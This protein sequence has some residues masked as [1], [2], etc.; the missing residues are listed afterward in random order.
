[1]HSV[2][3]RS[4]FQSTAVLLFGSILLSSCGGGSGTGSGNGGG[5]PPP[6][7][8]FSLTLPGN[9]SVQQGSTTTVSVSVTGI[10][11]FSSPV[12][13][14]LSGVPSGVTATPAQ[15]TLTTGA[16]QQIVIAA[17]A[18]AGAT[19]TDLTVSAT[20][21]ALAHSGQ[22]SLVVSAPQGPPPTLTRTAYVRTD[23]LWDPSFFNFFPQTL[24]VYDQATKRFFVSNTSLNRVDV[25][26][27]TT[28]RQIASIR[29][30]A[31][32]GGDES[33]DHKT[34]YLGTQV[35]DLY[36]IDPVGM[37]VTKRIPSIQIGPAGYAVYEVKALADGKLALLGG[38][39]GIPAVDGYSNFAIWNP[40]NNA[41]EQYASS[42]GAT[43]SATTNSPVCGSLE[44]IAEMTVTADRSKILLT[45]ADSDNTLCMFDPNT[46]TQRLANAP[47]GQPI[48]VPADGK[49]ILIATGNQVTVFDSASLTQTD[50]FEVNP[51]FNN[52]RFILSIDGNTLYGADAGSDGSLIVNWRTHQQSGWMQD[53]QVFDTPGTGLAVPMAI[54][55]TG[56]IASAI[57]HGVAFL[58]GA[59]SLPHA[60]GTTFPFGYN[61][62]IQPSFGPAAG[63]TAVVMT[64]MP[65]TD[66]ENVIFGSAPAQALSPGTSGLK[67]TTPAGTP[68][69]VTVYLNTA[70]L[71]FVLLPD[72]YSYGPSIV[73]VRADAT[74]AEGGGSGTIFGYGFGSAAFQGQAPGFQVAVGGQTAAVTQYL[75]QPYEQTTPYYPFPLEAVQFNFPAGTA[76]TFAD[77]SVSNAAGSDTAPKAVQYLPAVQQFP[78]AGASLIQGVYDS[79]RDV[80]YFTDQTQLRVF[81][82]TKS[83]WL[84]S[85]P[86]PA[87]A[88][89]LF[90]VSLSPNKSTLAVSDSGANLVYILDPDAPATVKTFA[91]PNSGVDQGE[92]PCGLAITDSGIAYVAT[93]Y[94]DFTGGPALH[95]V[96]TSTG[97]VSDYQGLAAGGLSDDAAIRVLLTNDND[98]VF[99]NI[100]GA[101]LSL[102]TA[103]D[104]F[105]FNPTIQGFDYEL[106]LSSNQTWMS[107]S[108]YLMDTNLNI[109]SY[110]TYN[111]RETWNQSA[112]YGEKI[113]ADGNL[114]FAPLMNGLDVIDGRLA[115]LRTRIGLPFTMSSNYDAL[116]D[117]GIDNILV[118][119]TGQT[120]GGVAV[121]DLSS[122]PEPT[123]SVVPQSLLPESSKY[124]TSLT[125]KNPDVRRWMN[126]SRDSSRLPGKL[127][128]TMNS[129]AV[130][131]AHRSPAK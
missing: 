89:R 74:T 118:A 124:S 29:V 78:L 123:S 79:K 76:G 97:V 131:S 12:N 33:V 100:A 52:Y 11:G 87:G 1:M 129:A 122:L 126:V 69:A 34:I 66:I 80:Y 91:L 26:D 106:T 110:V 125:T 32:W 105:F 49:E 96:N 103:T 99:F 23:V 119:I 111:D 42:Y 55:E 62:V 35:G 127:P 115:G 71:A 45:S 75:S 94:V 48:L 61:N 77:V 59:A 8:N 109:E 6:T 54:S 53:F 68:G 7:P 93:F 50:Q 67:L 102:D 121:I 47:N 25:F 57:G 24:V 90:G 46:L 5:T 21:G 81:S 72:G 114:L 3:S 27:A 14:V 10:N 95:K 15:F 101:V 130:I 65:A 40:S 38:Q 116:V 58:D 70:D 85:I 120:G 92:E 113:S 18:S 108:E 17:S 60:P 44:N 2:G 41:F 73:E 64:G 39:G 128:H 117:D 107:A 37:S 112:V 82:K 31:P 9:A 13:I 83:E 43:E 30:P 98:R 84:A 86:M 104:T 19:T 22:L 4:F 63:G 56:L 20:S 16:Q 88:T 51:G 28:E 36:E